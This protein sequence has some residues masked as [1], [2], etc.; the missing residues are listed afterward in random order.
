VLADHTS[1]GPDD[2]TG[3]IAIDRVAKKIIVSFR[4]SE[5]LG[6][7]VTNLEFG[8]EN[9]SDIC[10]GYQLPTGFFND[11][12]VANVSVINAVTQAT[13][14]AENKGYDVIVTGHSLGAAVATICAAVLRGNYSYPVTLVGDANASTV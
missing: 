1:L 11:W 6:N 14:A 10:Y 13:R 8:F 5:S 9:A 7:F 2:T 4:G 3:L 12:Q